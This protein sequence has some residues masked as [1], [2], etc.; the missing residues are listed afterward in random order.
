VIAIDPQGR[1]VASL[2]S[3]SGDSLRRVAV[4]LEF[5]FGSRDNRLLSPVSPDGRFVAIAAASG[6]VLVLPLEGGGSRRVPGSGAS[7]LPIQWTPDG[8]RLLLLNPSTLPGTI[9]GIDL[10]TGRRQ[11]LHELLPT[12]RA[13]VSGVTQ[14]LIPPDRRTYVYTYQRYRSDL[15]RVNGLR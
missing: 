7:D 13:G 5:R 6:G 4:P 11:V 2:V 8:R 14:A 3:F 12:D 10:A 15:Y 9:S 1:S